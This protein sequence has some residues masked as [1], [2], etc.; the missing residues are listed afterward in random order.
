[1]RIAAKIVPI[2][3]ASYIPDEERAMQYA[4]LLLGY[5]QRSEAEMRQRLERKTYSSAVIDRTL[6]ELTRLQLLD[7][8]EFARSWVAARHDRGPHR[9]KQEL[10]LKGIA[11][12]L[13][14]ETVTAG[15]SATDEWTAAWQV[16]TRA[17][18]G[19][20][21]P[22][23]RDELLRVRRLLGRRGFSSEAIRR[24][25]ARLN[26]QVTAEGDWLE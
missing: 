12:D 10:R 6:A 20:S 4:F 18:R 19:R 15:M 16:A 5:R 3:M 21:L 26:E 11:R 8:R 25:C 9:L 22:P 17:L 24:V 2:V 23:E 1:L 7:D 13:A 14:E